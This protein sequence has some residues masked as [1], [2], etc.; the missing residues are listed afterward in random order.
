ML[1]SKYPPGEFCSV[2]MGKQEEIH[3][4]HLSSQQWFSPDFLQDAVVCKLH[5]PCPHH[6]LG[7]TA[8]RASRLLIFGALQR[9]DSAIR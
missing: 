8:Q 4:T 2:R 7:I 3:G 6:G 5:V 1:L 9:N